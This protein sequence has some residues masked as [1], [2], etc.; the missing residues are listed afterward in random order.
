MVQTFWFWWGK[1]LKGKFIRATPP[2]TKM[3]AQNHTFEKENHLATSSIII[4]GVQ[5]SRV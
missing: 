2:K 5:F 1:E 4:F 3:E